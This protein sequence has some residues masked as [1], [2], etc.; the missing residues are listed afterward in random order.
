MQHMLFGI[1]LK[2]FL[3]SSRKENVN[4]I[5]VKP[6]DND[7]FHPSHLLNFL[8]LSGLSLMLVKFSFHAFKLHL[9]ILKKDNLYLGHF[10]NSVILNYR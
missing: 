9:K 10:P 1:F 4:C 2:F 7:Q 8:S 6:I 3:D 5:K